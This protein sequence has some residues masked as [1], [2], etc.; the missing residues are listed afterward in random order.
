MS[1]VTAK[2]LGVQV[3][4]QVLLQVQR[5]AGAIN[6]VPLLVKAIF[7]EA[8]IF[9]FYTLY[10]DRRVLNQALGH[11]PDYS[12]TIGVYLQD[13][14]S[15]ERAAAAVDKALNGQFNAAPL[16]T[17]MGELRTLLEALAVVS[18]GI[19]ALLAVVIAV[20]IL[21]LYRVLIYERVREIGT[22]RAIG[23]QR[24]QV[25]A[26]I[27][28]EAV[29]LAVCGIAAGFA[30]SLVVLWVLS[31]VPLKASA[32]LDIFLNQGHVSWVM[33][34]DT[35]A[36]DAL[37]IGAMVVAGAVNPAQAAQKTDP[38]VSLRTE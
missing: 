16:L 2:R 20:G 11:D 13:E 26:L 1:E 36:I 23:V 37:L 33:N 27:L 7:R 9:G 19:L 29:Y 3:G 12:G 38:V 18:Y 10:V 28:W 5:D 24:G 14:R 31:L 21:N 22:M 15:A 6:T 32:G 4:D 35:W 25:R 17:F 30:L 8:S 34:A